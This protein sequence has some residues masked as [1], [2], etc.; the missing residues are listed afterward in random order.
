MR[1]KNEIPIDQYIEDLDEYLKYNPRGIFSA[2]FGDGKSYMLNKFKEV[3]KEKYDIITLYP[4]NYQTSSNADIFELIKRDILIQLFMNNMITVE[5]CEIKE[6]K[7]A[8][9]ELFNNLDS[10]FDISKMSALAIHPSPEVIA[11]G[12]VVEV[13]KRIWALRKTIK[14]KKQALES[15]SDDSQLT[16]YLKAFEKKQGCIYEFDLVSNLI[17][18]A[19]NASKKKTILIIEDM[20]RLD[21]AHLFRILNVLAAHIDYKPVPNSQIDIDSKYPTNKF[22]FDNTLIVCDYENVEKIY[23]HIY[24]TTVDFDG[25][26]KKYTTST[27]FEYSFHLVGEHFFCKYIAGFLRIPEREVR[28]LLE[29]VDSN[30]KSNHYSIRSLLDA[31]YK[32]DEY[33]ATNNISIGMYNCK[34]E[35]T[36][37][38]VFLVLRLLGYKAEELAEFIRL[39][40]IRTKSLA[41]LNNTFGHLLLYLVP[42]NTH[43]NNVLIRSKDFDTQKEETY[44]KII[45]EVNDIG[46]VWTHE[47]NDKATIVDINPNL[48]AVSIEQIII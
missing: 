22:G 23:K 8:Q 27:P 41:E 42:P 16:A 9:Y 4:I 38:P 30:L 1:K 19:I 20:D 39:L 44:Y 48:I 17:Y 35:K 26:I 24:G 29:S 14:D 2:K 36:N 28:P 6:S 10:I 18:Q 31:I 43:L 12:G 34:I 45:A 47:V 15:V 46:L 37:L 32:V 25:Y 11:L 3:N 33:A 21:P 5:E 13:A 40:I 7:L